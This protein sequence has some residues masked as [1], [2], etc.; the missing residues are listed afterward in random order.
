M[1]DVFEAAHVCMQYD[2]YFNENTNQESSHIVI[3]S[4]GST[5]KSSKTHDSSTN[6]KKINCKKNKETKYYCK[7]TKLFKKYQKILK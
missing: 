7:V 3:N 6:N 4:D 5:E 2:P 1:C